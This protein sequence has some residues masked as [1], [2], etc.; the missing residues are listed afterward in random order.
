MER[1]LSILAPSVV[2]FKLFKNLKSRVE[3]FE[4]FEGLQDHT[5]SK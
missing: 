4:P 2:L 5:N 3:Y 1:D